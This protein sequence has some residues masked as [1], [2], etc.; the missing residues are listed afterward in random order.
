MD[1]PVLQA[2]PITKGML[3]DISKVVNIENSY[4]LCNFTATLIGFFLFLR[5]SNLVPDSHPHFNPQEQL[6][7]G[8]IGTGW[9][10]RLA[11]VHIEWSKTIQ[12]KKKELW[13]PVAPDPDRRICPLRHLKLMFERIPGGQ[14]DPCFQYVNRWK[15]LKSTHI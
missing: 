8:H 6:T 9:N 2:V 4:E 13:L 14:R 1:E 11:M 7:R 3:V 10:A 12:Y 5:A 15:V